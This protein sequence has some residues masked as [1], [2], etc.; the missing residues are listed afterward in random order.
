MGQG[1]G[2][3][4]GQGGGRGMSMNTDIGMPQ[5]AAPVPQYQASNTTADQEL[6]ALRQQAQAMSLHTEQLLERVK[7]LEQQGRSIVSAK[8]DAEK[9]TGCM[10]CVEVC[11]DGAISFSEG[12]AVIDQA[13]C[14]GCGTCVEM[15]PTDAISLE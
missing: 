6:S 9:C 15:C 5:A 8:V 3:G 13:V 12:V 1:G 11:S 4:M 2:R 7:Q 14:T 10:E